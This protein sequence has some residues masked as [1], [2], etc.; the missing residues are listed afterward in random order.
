MIRAVVAVVLGVLTLLAVGGTASADIAI[1]P[2]HARQLAPIVFI[3]VVM[4]RNI[5][6]P[7]CG[8]V[9]TG[10]W[11][12]FRVERRVSGHLRGE[13]VRVVVSCPEMTQ[14]GQ[15]YR[16]TV[17]DFA[18][19]VGPLSVRQVTYPRDNLRTYWERHRRLVR[20]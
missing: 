5:Q 1:S 12:T 9:H 18:P 7:A 15:R 4:E 19:P 17:R 13:V 11:V 3:G 2:L 8:R 20:R 10:G 14:V 16:V 6:H